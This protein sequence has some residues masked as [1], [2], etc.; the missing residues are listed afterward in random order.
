MK[1]KN[2]T[3]K[4]QTHYML[5]SLLLTAANRANILM[6]V[7]FIIFLELFDDAIYIEIIQLLCCAECCLYITVLCLKQAENCVIITQA[8]AHRLMPFAFNKPTTIIYNLHNHTYNQ[9]TLPNNNNLQIITVGETGTNEEPDVQMNKNGKFVIDSLQ[10]LTMQ[11]IKNRLAAAKCKLNPE[12]P[13]PAVMRNI[14]R[15]E[16]ILH[17]A[18]NIEQKRKNVTAREESGTFIWNF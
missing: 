13:S 14:Q 3:E 9:T 4:K 18:Q 11:E 7:F 12:K 2:N 16:K 8:I 5:M 1:D 6:R 15:W 17:A 10:E